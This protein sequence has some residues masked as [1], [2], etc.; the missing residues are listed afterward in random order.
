MSEF[1]F[2]WAHN[3]ASWYESHPGLDTVEC[4]RGHY[5]VRSD[6]MQWTLDVIYILSPCTPV[7]SISTAALYPRMALLNSP[8]FSLSIAAVSSAAAWFK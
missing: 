7:I 5:T 4:I 3:F 1:I 2:T 8:S 6:K